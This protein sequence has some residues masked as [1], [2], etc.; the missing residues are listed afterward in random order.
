MLSMAHVDLKKLREL[1]SQGYLTSQKHPEV[2]LWIF[3]Y[4]A[5]SQYDRYWT[6]ET[7]MSR[8]LIVSS[9]GEIVARPFEKFFNLDEYVGELP[10]EPFGV[11]EKLDGSL[12]IL[13]WIDDKPTIATRGSFMSKQAIAAMEILQRKY[14]RLI[15]DKRQTY[16]FEIIYPENK[17]VVDYGKTEELVLLAVRETETGTELDIQGIDVPFPKV[18][19]I[20][21]SGELARLVDI[22]DKNK[23]GFVV[24]YESGLRLKIKFSEYVRLHKLVT[25]VTSKVIWEHL[26]S[27]KGVEEMLSRVPDEFYGW[28]KNTKEKLEKDFGEIEKSVKSVV[29]KARSLGTRKE[30]AELIRKTR[31][32]GVAFAMLDGKNYPKLIWDLVRPATAKP[33]A[34]EV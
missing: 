30:Q 16:L 12:G 15:L 2:D 32:P 26:K 19:K 13:Y 9:A 7:I 20:D 24:R 1:V 25:G 29:E 18:E 6:N 17:I 31:H 14:P 33:F 5:K 22:Q 11:Y 10:D 27:G 4:T 23:E 21:W 34:Q 28:V 3:N 8:G